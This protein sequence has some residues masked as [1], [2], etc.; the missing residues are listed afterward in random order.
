MWLHTSSYSL[1]LRLLIGS[2]EAMTYGLSLLSDWLLST[3]LPPTFLGNKEVG[4]LLT[5]TCSHLFSKCPD[6]DTDLINNFKIIRSVHVLYY[7]P[8]PTYLLNAVAKK[9]ISDSE[10]RHQ[11]NPHNAR[12]EL[13]HF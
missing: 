3:Q 1:Q 8:Y 10:P 9:Y 5:F 7:A 4:A 13:G 11:V 12:I 2:M 6:D